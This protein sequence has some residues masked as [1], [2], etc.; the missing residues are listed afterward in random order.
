ME[1][2]RKGFLKLGL[3]AAAGGLLPPL[4]RLPLWGKEKELRGFLPA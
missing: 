1:I 2:N 3:T 4:L